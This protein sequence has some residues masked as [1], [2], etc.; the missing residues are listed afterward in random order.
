MENTEHF[1][2]WIHFGSSLVRLTVPIQGFL[3]DANFK[4]K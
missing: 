3:L 2:G 1:L 4:R